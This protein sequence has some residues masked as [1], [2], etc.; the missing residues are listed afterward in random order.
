MKNNTQ[1]PSP[2]AK[3]LSLYLMAFK[4]TSPAHKQ[5]S[6]RINKFWRLVTRNEMSSADYLKEV[7]QMLDFYG[8]Y[9]KVVEKTVQFYIKKTGAW[10]LKGN[11]KYCKDAKKIAEKLLKK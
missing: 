5:S 9:R 10:K 2:E 7:K 8:G 3:A 1:E 6:K 4:S 11:D